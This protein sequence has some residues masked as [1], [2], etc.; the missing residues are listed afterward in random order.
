[1]AI[2]GIDLGTTHSL[3]A[4]WT[5]KEAKIIPNVLGE[6]L[7]PSVVGVDDNGQILVGAPA[8]ERLITHP[9]HT[10]AL[11]KRYMGTEKRYQLGG[12]SF[13]PEELSSF[14]L[15]ALKNDA[16]AY[17]QETITEV[18]ISVPAYFGDK[19]RKATL[20]AG[21]LAGLQVERLIN[22]PTAAAIAYGIQEQADEA[23]MLI[24]DLGG[25][26]FDVSILELFEGTM[27]VNASGGNHS[28][29]GEDFLYGLVQHF[30]VENNVS[31]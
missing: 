23:N 22:E 19:Q 31:P 6:R 26:T 10:A 8:R 21:Q 18:V 25:G 2:V 30:C 1:M 4:Y 3:I 24:F 11:F 29:G 16:E 13:R 28:V 9:Q 27:E 7:T 12:H 5:D 17:L 15:L 20:A 14:V